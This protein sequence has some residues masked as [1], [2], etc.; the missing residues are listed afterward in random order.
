MT[1]DRATALHALPDGP[2]IDR[3]RAIA[4]VA[5]LLEALGRDLADEDIAGTPRRVV[6]GFVEMLTPRPFEMTTFPN[7]AG[8]DEPV[9]V[10][11]IPFA[12]LCR[13]HLLPFRGTATV[14]YLPG[15]RLVGLSKLARVVELHAHELQVQESLTAQVARTLDE[16]L[17]PRGVAVVVE[18]EHLCM[19]V[20]GVRAEGATTVTSAF[21]GAFAEDP[22]LRAALAERTV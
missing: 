2:G 10:R 3:E 5:D 15:A 20:R 4:A 8:Y 6:D 7:D 19:S 17:E 21:R 1:T 16:A 13:H 11:G 14:A 12:S 9:V 22:A 18:A